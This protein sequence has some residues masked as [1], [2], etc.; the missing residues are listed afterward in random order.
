MNIKTRFERKEPELNLQEAEIVAVEE[1]NKE[2][3]D[4][5]RSS[6]LLDY[7]FIQK[8]ENDLYDDGYRTRALL[9]L[10]KDEED[11]ILVNSE[12]SSYARYS[13]YLPR[14]RL[15]LSDEI[16]RV[17]DAILNGRFGESEDG[18]WL[19]GFDDI[20]EHLDLTVTPNNGIGTLLLEE[21][22]SREEIDQVIATE[23]SLQITEALEQMPETAT[24]GERVLTVFSLMGCDLEDVHLL[25]ADEEHD[26]ATIVELN[27]NTLT[28]QGKQDWADVLHA[29]VERIYEGPYG[30][31]IDVSGCDPERLRA[32]SY[33]LAGYCSVEDSAKWLTEDAEE[34][35]MGGMTL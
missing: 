18:A 13:S 9:V 12:G 6:L 30:I 29:K 23:D 5:F 22:E 35:R 17:A 28:E 26:L 34:Q 11:G 2:Q 25:D 7:D 3:F 10:C 33:M 19:V 32:F 14:A 4:R 8:H 24:A 20:K 27:Q 31:Q 16:R 15:I 21:L 1:L